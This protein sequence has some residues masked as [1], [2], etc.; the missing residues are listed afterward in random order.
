MANSKSSL[1]AATEAAARVN[2]L[3]IAK[4][5]LK[6]PPTNK[7]KNQMVAKT[8]GELYMAE[9]EINDAP[10][11]ARNMLTRGVT[12]D[13]IN[14]LS[15][16][17]VSTRGRYMTFDD[18]SKNPNE[19][20]LYL[21]VQASTKEAVDAA[22]DKIHKI[23]EQQLKA[24]GSTMNWSRSSTTT[25]TGPTS[26]SSATLSLYLPPP[27]TGHYVQDKVFVGLEH[28]PTAFQLKE[29][30]LGPGELHFNHIRV[31]TGATVT[32]RG[33]GSGFLDPNSGREAFEPLHIHLIHSLPKGLQSAKE[34]AVNLIQTM[35]QEYAQWQQQ[36]TLAVLVQNP[37]SAIGVQ[38]VAIQPSLQQI[39]V[40]NTSALGLNVAQDVTDLGVAQ[41]TLQN[42]QLQIG[43]VSSNLI[44]N[45]ALTATVP[46]LLNPTQGSQLQ[47]IQGQVLNL[48]SGI[49]SVVPTVVP[50]LV[51]TSA[52]NVLPQAQVVYT[53][54]YQHAG[55]TIVDVSQSYLITQPQVT[56]TSSAAY[57]QQQQ[58]LAR[59]AA[60]QTQQVAAHGQTASSNA[61]M[62][63]LLPQATTTTTMAQIHN[64]AQIKTQQLIAQAQN[65]S[66]LLSQ[67]VTPTY[68]LNNTPVTSVATAPN[69]MTN[70]QYRIQSETYSSQ[71]RKLPDDC[72]MRETYLQRAGRLS[73]MPVS[74][75]VVPY[76]S[77]G[78][79]VYSSG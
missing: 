17:A 18:I 69:M 1:E 15:G 77:T 71:K 61:S 38:Q 45:Q 19:R 76:S 48:G 16:A 12:Q 55:Q 31:E 30:L 39:G 28:V 3:L 63:Y 42:A 57:Q 64:D 52:V 21:H 36:Q 54:A 43:S 23:I 41:T 8:S 66:R 44:Q 26:S 60:L 59:V 2:A 32:L 47:L 37:T 73:M 62:Y 53:P 46:R 78:Y 29:K 27:T 10:L 35:Q 25:R 7:I 65:Q 22:V 49:A 51:S 11:V 14:K 67:R 72:D 33:K 13:E 4:G 24:T 58:Q 70:L 79:S 6:L 74:Q 56:T 20:P 9:I 75:S 5:K 68:V 34:L 40:V 50:A